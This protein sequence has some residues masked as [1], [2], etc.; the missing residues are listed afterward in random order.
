MLVVNKLSWSACNTSGCCIAFQSKAGGSRSNNDAKGT[1]RKRK[2]AL[3]RIPTSTLTGHCPSQR[4]MPLLDCI[5]VVRWCSILLSCS[6][7]TPVRPDL[8]S[9]WRIASE[10]EEAIRQQDRKS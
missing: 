1:P 7:V 4:D 5:F 8:R 2:N 3:A 6:L 9:C 10:R